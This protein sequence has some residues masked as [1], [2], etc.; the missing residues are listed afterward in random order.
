MSAPHTV[1]EHAREI[2]EDLCAYIDASPSPYHC[3]AE[4]A[5]RLQAAGFRRLEEADVWSK[6]SGRYYLVRGGSLVAWVADGAAAPSRGFHIVA[7]HT[8]SPNLR[9]KAKPNTASAGWRQLGV[10][11][12]GGVL[13]NSW[14]DRDLGLS[15]RVIVRSGAGGTT[16]SHPGATEERL[17]KVDQPLARVPQ[18]AIHLDRGVNDDG[19]VLDKQLHLSPVWALGELE[20]GGLERFV[21]DR[22]EVEPGDLLSFELMLHDVQGSKLIGRDAEMVAAPRL[23]NQSSCHHGLLALLAALESPASS[24]RFEHTPVLCLFDHEEVGSSSRSGAMGSVLESLLGRVVTVSGGSAEDVFRARAN[25][26]CISAD[27][28]H[29]THPN[30]VDR[31]EPAHFIELNRGPVIKLNSNQR[32]A[33]DA[34]SEALFIQCCEA[35]GVPLQKYIHRSNLGCGS[36][37]GPLTAARLGIRVVD[38][39]NPQLSMHSSRELGG[40]LDPAYMVAALTSFYAS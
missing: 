37:I 38:V 32:Y 24:G 14:L 34:E 18:L 19:L 13:L 5:R 17:I 10:E 2:A 4:T 7:G 26:V 6:D 3:V 25:S 30:Y 11:V 21:A 31:H 39:G 33:T 12:Y 36:T 8:D 1:P 27:M 23:D 16:G 15:G 20:T 29:A 22:L 35:A 40:S 9:I 28:A